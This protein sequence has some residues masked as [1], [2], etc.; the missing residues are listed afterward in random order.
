MLRLLALIARG[1]GAKGLDRYEPPS[2]QFEEWLREAGE[3]AG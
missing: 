2:E 3:E 1:L